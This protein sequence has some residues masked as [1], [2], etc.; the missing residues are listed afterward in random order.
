MVDDVV[1]IDRFHVGLRIR[2]IHT[3]VENHL[4]DAFLLVRHPMAVMLPGG[5]DR[6]GCAA[7]A[8]LEPSDP[9]VFLN[10]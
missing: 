3:P 2:H 6:I 10:T 9:Y 8:G 1:R 4:H 7:V 5:T